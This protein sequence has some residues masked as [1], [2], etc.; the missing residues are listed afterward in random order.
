MASA[1]TIKETQAIIDDNVIIARYMGDVLERNAT[2]L[3]VFTFC[4]HHHIE[5]AD[6]YSFFSSLESV[7]SAIWVKFF[8]NTLEV[9]HKD[10]SYVGY[11]NRNKM[12]TLYFTFFEI[13]TLNRSY[14][15]FTLKE[16][17]QGLKNLKQLRQLRNRFRDYIGTLIAD[18]NA[19]NEGKQKLQKITKPVFAEGAWVQ[20]LFILK[21]WLDDTSAGFEKT[22]I[23]IEKT[24]KAGFDVMDITPLESLLDLGKFIW[25]ERN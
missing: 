16:N 10:I 7:R 14:F 6:F 1:K 5:E 22:D 4:R 8:E 15:Y 21:F 20:F 24:V 11:S 23:M 19:T 3:N 13:L 12:L 18:E 9:L 2:P 17:K 25:K